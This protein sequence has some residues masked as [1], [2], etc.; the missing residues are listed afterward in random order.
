MSAQGLKYMGI[1]LTF[2]GIALL[3]STTSGHRCLTPLAATTRR[4]L[5]SASCLQLRRGREKGRLGL[6]GRRRPLRAA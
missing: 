6:V 5:R 1:G 2:C 3:I 4:R